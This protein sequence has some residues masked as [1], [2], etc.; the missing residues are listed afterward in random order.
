MLLNPAE[1]YLQNKPYTADRARS[2]SRSRLPR[3]AT[4]SEHSLGRE[5]YSRTDSRLARGS[6]QS[7]DAPL[8]HPKPS[9]DRLCRAATSAG[10]PY[11]PTV[12]HAHLMRGSSDTLS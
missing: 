3:N 5:Q 1:I 10:S 9:S 2:K 7:A 4:S 8:A 11:Q 6:P 12:S